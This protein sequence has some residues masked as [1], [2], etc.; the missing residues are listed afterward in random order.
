MRV[1]PIPECERA[2]KNGPVC[3][4]LF[5]QQPPNEWSAELPPLEA[6]ALD[7][8]LTHADSTALLTW[9]VR[10]AHSL[11]P[12]PGLEHMLR[13]SQADAKGSGSAERKKPVGERQLSHDLTHMW[14][15]MINIM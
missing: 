3:Q 15:M 10:L 7:A 13:E 4:R 12:L 8:A 9:R 11:L 1:K 2:Y 14:D 5:I 6:L